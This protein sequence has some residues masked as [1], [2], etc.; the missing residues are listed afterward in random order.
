MRHYSLLDHIAQQ[1]D[2]AIRTVHSPAIEQRPSPATP[3]PQPELNAA[4]R[5]HT[6]GLMRVN[7]VGEVCAQGLYQGQAMMA[8]NP[9]H[10]QMLLDAAI[11]EVDHLAWTEQR[12]TELGS[13]TSVFNPLWY[14]GSFALGAIAGKVSDGVSLGFV[15]ETEKQVGDHLQSHLDAEGLPAH[16][17]RSRAIVSTMYTEELEHAEHARQAGAIELPNLVKL[18]MRGM[19]KIMTTTAYR[20]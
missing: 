9:Q 5:T 1:I 20:L 14:I 10:R 18:A 15:V 4:E 12:L 8:K 13:R 16:D 7:H 2:H 17:E 6:A 3:L 19:A 11:E